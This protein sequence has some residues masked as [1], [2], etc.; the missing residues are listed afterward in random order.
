MKSTGYIFLI[1]I[2]N[3]F[4]GSMPC[5][6][7]S[8]LD[9]MGLK[10]NV[11]TLRVNYDE[12][13]CKWCAEYAFDKDGNLAEIG[14]CPVDV[15]RDTQS[16]I[17]RCTVAVNDENGESFL[18]TSTYTYDNHFHVTSISRVTPD[19]NWA[20]SYTYSPDGRLLSRTFSYT[21]GVES[22]DYVY[23]SQVDTTGNWLSRTG[24]LADSQESLNESRL[25]VYYE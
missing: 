23:N 6:A 7:A 12:G 13:G 11:Q 20:E 5:F 8:D 22:L 2:L 10:G 25:I 24:L 1:V 21:D 9:M 17:M 18:M 14:G 19:S 16:R 15:E 4:F 3:A